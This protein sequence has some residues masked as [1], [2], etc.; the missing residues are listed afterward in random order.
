METTKADDQ[1][2][3]N[4]VTG[5]TSRWNMM[6]AKENIFPPSTPPSPDQAVLSFVQ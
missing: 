1:G 3:H 5:P 6:G 2:G 4:A